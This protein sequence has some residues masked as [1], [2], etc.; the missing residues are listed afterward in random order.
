MHQDHILNAS[1][2]WRGGN[3]ESCL[4]Q[5]SRAHQG[6]C[7]RYNCVLFLHDY[8]PIQFDTRFGLFKRFHLFCPFFWICLFRLSFPSACNGPQSVTRESPLKR[9]AVVTEIFETAEMGKSVVS[10]KKRKL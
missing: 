1:W 9:L 4:H 8:S 3:L 7:E 6:S 2:R 5:Q 10:T